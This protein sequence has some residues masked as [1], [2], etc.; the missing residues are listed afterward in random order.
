MLER[1]H[2]PSLRTRAPA[3][4]PYQDLVAIAPLPGTGRVVPGAGVGGMP[5]QPAGMQE[6]IVWRYP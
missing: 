4:R 3:F 1:G 6:S 5:V 2:G